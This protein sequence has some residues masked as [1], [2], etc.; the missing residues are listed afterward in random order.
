MGKKS[1]LWGILRY[2]G[3]F[4]IVVLG[5]ITIVGT[6]GSGGGG[7]SGDSSGS[8]AT[9]SGT[10]AAG[11]P[12]IGKVTI[13]DSSS[14]AIT[15]DYEISADG[16]YSFDVS[17]M[18]PPFLFQAKGEVGG[19]TVTLHSAATEAD[20]NG[21]INVTPLTDLIVSNMARQLAENYFDGYNPVDDAITEADLNE[22]EQNLKD[23]LEPILTD[24]GLDASIDLLRESFSANHEGLDAVLDI[25]RVTPSD[26]QDTVMEIKNII[27]DQVLEDDVTVPDETDRME[28]PATPENSLTNVEQAIKNIRD[29]LD[30]FCAMF[31]DSLPAED[32]PDL[33][34]KVS[35]NLLDYG[36]NRAQFLGELTTDP[37]LIGL[38]LSN[39]CLEEIDL[40]SNEAVI[41]FYISSAQY[42]PVAEHGFHMYREDGDW[43]LGGNQRLVDIDIDPVAVY[44]Q[45]SG[46]IIE[47]GLSLWVNDE[48]GAAEGL[49]SIVVTGPGLPQAGIDLEKG[50]FSSWY[51][52][53][54]VDPAEIGLNAEYQVTLYDAAS[55]QIAEY[56]VIVPKGPKLGDDLSKEDFAEITSPSQAEL[57]N[58]TGGALSCTWTMPERMRPD[59]ARLEWYNGG[60]RAEND[61]DLAPG[62]TGATLD[63][64]ENTYPGAIWLEIE[65]EDEYG[66]EFITVLDAG[67]ITYRI[68][69]TAYIQYRSN[70]DDYYVYLP[71]TENGQPISSED[72]ADVNLYNSADEEIAHANELFWRGDYYL[73]DCRSGA[74]NILGPYQEAGYVAYGLDSL[75]PETYTVEL[76]PYD[77]QSARAEIF[78]PGILDLPAV[79]S[80]TMESAWDNSDNLVLSWQNPADGWQEVDQLR[81]VLYDY[82]GR[83]LSFVLLDP[84]AT[85]VTIPAG[86]LTQLAGLRDT[87]PAAWQVQA[88]A[89]D[90]NGMS[91]AFGGSVY[92]PVDSSA[93]GYSFG[94]NSYLQYRTNQDGSL[95]GY[96]GYFPVRK[97][98]E[99]ITREDIASVTVKDANGNEVAIDGWEVWSASYYY[100]TFLETP[101][102]EYGPLSE[103]GVF[104][105]FAADLAEGI[106]SVEI[107]TT[108][109]DTIYK[110]IQ[111]SAQLALPVVDSATMESAWDDSGNLVLSWENPAS[112]WQDVDQVRVVLYDR[113]ARE[114]VYAVSAPESAS[115]RQEVTIP[116]DTINNAASLKSRGTYPAVWVV[117]TDARD[118]NGMA[119]AR[120]FSEH[121]VFS[122]FIDLAYLQ[123]VTFEDGTTAWESWVG[124][125]NENGVVLE[126]LAGFQVL[127]SADSEEIPLNSGI[128][129]SP[130]P[131]RFY[132]CMEVNSWLSEQNW[133]IGYMAAF[134]Y[135]EHPE[136][137]SLRVDLA[138]QGAVIAKVSVPQDVEM[139]VISE[140]S[141][142]VTDQTDSV[143]VQWSNPD[144]DPNWARVDEIHIVYTF[145]DEYPYEVL[146]VSV[147]PSAE[148]V[149]I[150]DSVIDTVLA[151]IVG[152]GYP[153]DSSITL[154]Q[155]RT[156]AY[157]EDGM[158]YA[159]G[160]S[161]QIMNE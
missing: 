45:S 148:S 48:Y 49:S 75:P 151:D 69:P 157:N 10:V 146:I 115:S 105:A 5:L 53:Y 89:L 66:R 80:Q 51:S 3:L 72:I 19:R 129:G 139:P 1:K 137:Y 94:D 54:Q 113:Y 85:E 33:L 12:V 77:G 118:G 20:V 135:I 147:P 24:I 126:D 138:D 28:A 97:D 114:L 153:A 98:G 8:A 143:L 50:E 124:L 133:L 15:E 102:S 110:W 84:S 18:T 27:T 70:Q 158:Q 68:A 29:T 156:V 152:L 83:E 38:T 63:M 21:C 6:G 103:S 109:G 160:D 47:N 76:I 59:Y 31:A 127:D 155:I 78:Y 79:D 44:D 100:Y 150:P 141:V 88:L 154:R 134:V 107:Q 111:A 90:E 101:S 9:I 142:T 36:Q 4:W 122:Y 123:Q 32:N 43:K 65:I 13:K 25:L 57:Y 61:V 82:D 67:D 73:Y 131:W 52:R 91:Y 34:D 159:R 56:T 149:E 46:T 108:G 86:F 121:R 55:E 125:L 60:H 62:D 81:V 40:V 144:G 161:D 120:G 136:D 92:A 17:G 99:S 39:V 96:H 22:A 130:V 119:C 16:S 132:D 37:G 145:T 35:E 23:R 74:S 140:S 64:P 87:N 58:F 117:Q 11:A 2:V 30:D 93:G 112:G 128:W 14:P 116:V 26:D 106:Y 41:T 7:S 104:C 42:P 71:A 95:D